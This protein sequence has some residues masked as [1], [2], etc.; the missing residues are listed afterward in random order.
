MAILFKNIIFK[1]TLVVKLEIIL[2]P[3]INNVKN[4]LPKNL[5]ISICKKREHY[6]TLVLHY[7]FLRI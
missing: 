1:V 6:R 3:Y 2:Y 4:K 7:L 5:L